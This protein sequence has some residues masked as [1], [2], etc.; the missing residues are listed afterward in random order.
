MQSNMT[1]NNINTNKWHEHFYIK[2]TWITVDK[3][4]NEYG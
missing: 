4:N 2:R 3:N 1:N